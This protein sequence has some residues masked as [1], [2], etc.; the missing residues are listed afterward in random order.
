MMLLIHFEHSL[1]YS[2]LTDLQEQ[3]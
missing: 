2:V 1:C 3:Q